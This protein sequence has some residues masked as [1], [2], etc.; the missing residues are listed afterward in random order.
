MSS[1]IENER[2]NL[3]WWPKFAREMFEAIGVTLDGKPLDPKA[4]YDIEAPW[5]DHRIEINYIS[6][7]DFAAERMEEPE[8][9]YLIYVSGDRYGGGRWE[10]LQAELDGL[11]AAALRNR[12]RQPD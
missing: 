8:G 2:S 10:F 6:R 1:N 12:P 3:G 7:A 4:A 5:P 9:K 11:I